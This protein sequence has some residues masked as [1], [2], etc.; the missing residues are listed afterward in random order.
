MPFYEYFCEAN[1]RTVEVHH[2]IAVR[3]KSWGEVCKAAGIK[4]GK[5]A[6]SAKVI[7]MIGRASPSVFRLK[8]LDKDA[9]SG[10]FNVQQGP[11]YLI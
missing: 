9:P 7:R 3:L 5:T 6:R 4:P 8:G 10:K 11:G 1:R 2:A